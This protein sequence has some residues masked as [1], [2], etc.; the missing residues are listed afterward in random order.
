[1]NFEEA[2]QFTANA[3]VDTTWVVTRPF[4]SVGVMFHARVPSLDHGTLNAY[5]VCLNSG[6]DLWDIEGRLGTLIENLVGG[7]RNFPST[8]RG[9]VYGHPNLLAQAKALIRYRDRENRTPYQ[10]DAQQ[11][12]R[13]V[14]E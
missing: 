6:E 12:Q 1:M 14:H 5:F 9:T 2:V 13:S 8:K 4:R 10:C 11:I 3:W 7:Q